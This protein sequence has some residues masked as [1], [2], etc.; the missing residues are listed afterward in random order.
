MGGVGIDGVCEFIFLNMIVCL[1]GKVG[2]F[3]GNVGL[4]DGLNFYGFYVFCV[5][6]FG[7][8][9]RKF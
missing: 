2:F 3:R 1:F 8:Y 9:N 5:I 4:R 7:F 6:R